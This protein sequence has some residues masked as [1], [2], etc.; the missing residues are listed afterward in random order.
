MVIYPYQKIDVEIQLDK[1]YDDL[2]EGGT[3][4]EITSTDN[5]HL[6]I[7]SSL[8]YW[9]IYTPPYGKR[10]AVEPMSFTGNV[11][12]ISEA[13]FAPSLSSGEFFIEAWS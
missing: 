2:F 11:Y 9:Q 1:K 3:F 13:G 4:L 12:K 8:P 5:F 10:I 7:H 6:K